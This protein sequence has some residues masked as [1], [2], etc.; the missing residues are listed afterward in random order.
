MSTFRKNLECSLHKVGILRKI[1]QFKLRGKG[2]LITSLLACFLVVSCVD[3]LQDYPVP[4]DNL[5]REDITIDYYSKGKV[6]VS[7]PQSK[8]DAIEGAKGFVFSLYKVDEG[9]GVILETVGE[10]KEEVTADFVERTQEPGAYYLVEMR[11]LGDGSRSN[12]QLPITDDAIIS[13]DGMRFDNFPRSFNIPITIDSIGT[14][15]NYTFRISWEGIT[16]ITITGKDERKIE[17]ISSGLLFSLYE[18]DITGEK[19]RAIGEENQELGANITSIERELGGSFPYYMVELTVLGM[20]EDKIWPTTVNTTTNKTNYP[21]AINIPTGTNLTQYFSTNVLSGDEPGLFSLDANGTYTMTGDIDQGTTP[22][23]IS[24]LSKAEPAKI[25]VTNGSFINGGAEFKLANVEMDYSGHTG[26]L[27]ST[28]VVMMKEALPAGAELTFTGYYVTDPISFQSCKITGIKS[29]FFYD[30]GAKYALRQLNI[31]DC[32][33]GFDQ[34][35]TSEPVWN[36]ATI[37]FAAG[38]AKEIKFNNS[39][40]YNETPVETGDPLSSRRFIQFQQGNH[41]L[42]EADPERCAVPEWGAEEGITNF[43]GRIIITNCTFYQLVKSQQFFNTNRAMTSQRGAVYFTVEK[44]VFVDTGM[45]EVIRRLFSSQ[46]DGSNK[47]V[48]MS[49]NAYWYKGAF[50]TNEI[51]SGRDSYGTHIETDP[52]LNYVGNGRFTMTGAGFGDPRWK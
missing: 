7:W 34:P 3:K 6:R 46:G 20:G 10:W 13:G 33:I 12:S 44:N 52:G 30:G 37:R 42:S 45:G 47:I 4:L 27:A 11:L 9:G 17:D 19:I 49:E 41:P 40:F 23:M 28:A 26:A 18:T 1:P 21:L 38:V 35:L 24:G 25:T 36:A 29:Y 16:P 48:T 31:D 51:S 2:G 14:P 39:T 32:I 50:A 15:D 5:S 22:L 43:N 8:I